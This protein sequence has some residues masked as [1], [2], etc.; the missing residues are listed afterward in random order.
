M[1]HSRGGTCL[2][3]IFDT[4]SERCL[5]AAL[6][7]AAI[8]AFP[9]LSSA[10]EPDPPPSADVAAKPEIDDEIVVSAGL[11]PLERAQVGS[12]VTVLTAEDL[13]R[14]R[15]ATVADA[16]RLVPGLE[17]SRTGGPGQLTSLF[18]RGGSS[19]QALVLVDGVRLNSATTGAVDFAALSTDGLERIEVLRGPQSTLYGSEAMAG[20]VS[21]VTRR[22]DSGLAL[23]AMVEVGEEDHRRVRLRAAGGDDSFGWNV[24]GGLLETEDTF[25]ADPGAGNPEPDA[26]ENLSAVA[27]FDRTWSNGRGQ[28]DGALRFVDS[29]TQ[30]DGFS[31]GLGP[32]DDLDAS[33]AREAWIASFGVEV[34]V[35]R[36]WRQSARFGWVQDDLEGRDPGNPFGDFT[37]ESRRIE[38][39]TQ[40]DLDLG[41]HRLSFGGGLEQREG[42]SVGNF[43]EDV[44]IVSVFVQDAWSLGQ[45]STVS[46]G[47]RYDDH[48]QFGDET[49]VRATL[50][51]GFGRGGRVHASWGTGFKAPTFNDLY[52]PFFSNPDL[53]AETSTAWDLG[54]E[55]RL[56]DDR[57]TLGVT[58]FDSE[59]EDLIAFDF[60]T[61]LPQNIS[62]ATSE[63]VEATLAWSGERVD[64]RATWTWNETED[65]T[66]GE[67]LARRPERRATL[68]VGLRVN[69]RLRL[70]AAAYAVADRIDSDGSTL[71]DAERLDLTAE[72]AI[73]EHLRP[74]L[75]LLNVFDDDTSEVSGYGTRGR[76]GVAGLSASW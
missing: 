73:G 40:A 46:L 67:Q 48:E 16:L 38:A 54:V 27:S 35:S 49:T 3:S 22:G 36:T 20:V 11:V 59:F 63:G 53:L 57:L 14:H 19:S 61:F 70:A 6:C 32:V 56:A 75:R 58:V 65:E 37:I 50:A 66:T 7:C 52:F 10:A 30:I 39:S 9:I 51:V 25:A 64:A 28:L 55:Q 8:F 62:E 47:A 18:I 31:F 41:V 34:P 33:T 74:Y 29:D 43:D 76:A 60:V 1:L 69:D 71:D 21:L 5:A 17:V 13:E 4:G 72:L 24:V 26:W 45:R 44:E 68:D 15:L 42:A 23:G 2:M 12:S